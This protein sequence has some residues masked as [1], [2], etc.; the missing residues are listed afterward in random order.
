MARQPWIEID[1]RRPLGDSRYESADWPH[2]DFTSDC[3]SASI[4]VASSLVTELYEKGRE[5]G[6]DLVDYA[7]LAFTA[8][9]EAILHPSIGDALQKLGIDAPR[10][11]DSFISS[12][13]Q[14]IVTDPDQSNRL[15]VRVPRR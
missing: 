15:R 9:A 4:A 7:H 14:Y 11:T 10:M 8:G 2:F 5:A 6:N 12:P 1:L 13:F 3:K